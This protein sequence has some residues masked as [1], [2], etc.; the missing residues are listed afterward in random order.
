MVYTRRQFFIRGNMGK[1]AVYGLGHAICDII[2]RIS[3]DEF[4]S[5]SLTKGS[6]ELVNPGGSARAFKEVLC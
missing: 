5:L 3:E 6:M 2:V 4:K 1:L